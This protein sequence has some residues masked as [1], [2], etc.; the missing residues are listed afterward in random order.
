MT[1]TAEKRKDSKKTTIAVIAAVVVLLGFNLYSFFGASLLLPGTEIPEITGIDPDING[2][3]SIDLSKGVVVLNIWATWCPACLNEMYVLKRAAGQ[4]TIYGAIK[5]PFKYETYRGFT[6]GFRSL[7]L[8]D[9]FF[10]KLHISALPTT[11]LLENG[12]IKKVHTGPV[13]D[14]FLNEWVKP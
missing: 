2:V 10:E 13:S 9:E 6:T 12:V 4:M 7:I 5:K 1:E 8:E 11:L 14:D 3:A